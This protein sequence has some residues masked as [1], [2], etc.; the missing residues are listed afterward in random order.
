M[1]TNAAIAPN[2]LTLL[3]LSGFANSFLQSAGL[4]TYRPIGVVVQE[5]S[6]LDSLKDA[7]PVFE[8]KIISANEKPSSFQAKLARLHD[9]AALVHFAEGANSCDNLALLYESVLTGAIDDEDFCVLPLLIFD[10]F[11]PDTHLDNLSLIFEVSSDLQQFN[12]LGTEFW[13][14]LAKLICQNPA[15]F[16]QAVRGSVAGVADSAKLLIGASAILKHYFELCGLPTDRLNT[17]F[18]KLRATVLRSLDFTENYRASDQIVKA[19]LGALRA[20]VKEGRLKVF[21]LNSGNC[22]D[23]SSLFFDDK[24]YYLTSESF[25]GVLE[26]INF[27]SSVRIKS[28]LAQDGILSLEGVERNYYTKKVLLE[29]GSSKRFLCLLRTEIDNPTD[30]SLVELGNL[31]KK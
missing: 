17:I 4:R 25:A 2:W 14:S 23:N 20:S 30:I 16:R 24:F 12:G 9:D 8:H 22:F 26:H 5:L 15:S 13:D 18:K 31:I 28:C 29:D 3:K 10:G 1:Q 21:P 7:L 19:F 11:V 6:C 27:I